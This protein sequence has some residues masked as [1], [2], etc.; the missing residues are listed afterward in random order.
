MTT[1]TIDVRE[2][3][4]I[5]DTPASR[6]YVD[7]DTLLDE[8]RTPADTY[9]WYWDNA[10]DGRT[11]KL[12]VQAYGTPME[13][14]HGPCLIAEGRDFMVLLDSEDVTPP[15]TTDY[16]CALYVDEE[17]NTPEQSRLSGTLPF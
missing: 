16:C 3:R 10:V 13:T 1:T 14:V 6:F 11:L 4:R 5:V 15:C 8:K 7:K 2:L 9:R 12:V 17:G